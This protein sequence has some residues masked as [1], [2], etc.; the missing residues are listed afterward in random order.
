GHHGAQPGHRG[1]I[2]ERPSRDAEGSPPGAEEPPCDAGG[3]PGGGRQ[4]RG[5][6]GG[7][8]CLQPDQ[9][10]HR[11]R[12]QGRGDRDHRSLQGAG[13]AEG[14]RH[15]AQG[16]RRLGRRFR[17]RFRRRHAH[18]RRAWPRRPDEVLRR[19]TTTMEE[20]II[21]LRG[22]TKVYRVGVETIHALRGVDLDI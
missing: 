10:D 16:I 5:H 9:H 4:G 12:P 1:A 8:R 7:D 20:P 11:R 15:G 3:V 21:Q 2:G 22:I 17:R 18:G 6:R 13:A 19:G 14:R